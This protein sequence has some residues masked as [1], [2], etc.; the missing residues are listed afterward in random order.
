MLKRLHLRNFTVFEDAEFEFGPGLNVV[1]GTNG[2]GKSHVLKAGYVMQSDVLEAVFASHINLKDSVLKQW[3]GIERNIDSLFLDRLPRIFQ[4]VPSQAQE[5]IR[6]GIKSHEAKIAVNITFN[7]EE[8]V[9][10]ATFSSDSSKESTVVWP[11]DVSDDFSISGPVFIPAKEV[12]TMGWLL[13]LYNYREIQIDETY[14]DLLKLLSIPTLKLP[15]P[16]TL[17]VQVKLMTLIGGRVEEE[18]GRFYLSVPKQP[19]MEM[20][21]VA[22]GMRKFATLYK[23]LA[24]GTLTSETTLFWDE[25]EANLNPALLKEMAAVLAELA[26]AGFQIILATHS[27]FLLK[28][29]HILS[30]QA[31]L[32]IK[33]FGLSAQPGEASTVTATDNLELLPDIVALD[34]EL[35]QSDRF[36]RVLDQEDANHN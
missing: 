27:L 11:A 1:V 26:R 20:N 30:R 13:P 35:E 4:P 5:L 32:P 23:L 2:T 25:P 7:A 10:S 15:M 36:Q 33:Y 24:N 12:L 22:E 6:R 34:A 21:L 17:D 19:R 16:E 31:P 9:C 28:E 18:G 3:P 29:L 14:P 8:V